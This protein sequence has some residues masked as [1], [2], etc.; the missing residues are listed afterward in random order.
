MHTCSIKWKNDFFC[1]FIVNITKRN[2][3]S[4]RKKIAS[5]RFFLKQLL[6]CY[7]QQQNR[8]RTFHKSSFR[9]KVSLFQTVD[10]SLYLRHRVPNFIF[11]EPPTVNEIIACIGSLNTNKA[12]GYD[13]IPA[14]F[15][16][17]AAPI[18]APYLCFLIDYAFFKWNFFW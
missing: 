2:C 8:K 5:W 11:F 16:K 1:L 4:S 7:I 13:N 18:I 10:F 6:T 12:V 14:Y 17:V 9:R 3:V 15:L